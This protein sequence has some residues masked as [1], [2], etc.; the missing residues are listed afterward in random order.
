[1]PVYN[2]NEPIEI[3]KLKYNCPKHGD[4]S[5][6]TVTVIKGEKGRKDFC[7]PCM[8]EYWES[9]GITAISFQ[10]ELR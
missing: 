8:V 4:V 3:K 9:Q 2:H 10:E 1:M 5:M 7:L 6:Q